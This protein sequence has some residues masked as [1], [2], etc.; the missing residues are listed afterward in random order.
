MLKTFSILPGLFA[1]LSLLTAVPTMAQQP[2]LSGQV[3]DSATGSPLS[4]VYI[5]AY[6]GNKSTA[7][8]YTDDNGT[9][10]FPEGRIITAVSASLLGYKAAM[11]NIVPGTQHIEIRMTP[12]KLE[13]R[14]ASVQASVV[15]EKGD[16]LSYTAQAFADGTER[17]L[18]ELLEK[19]PGIT[20]NVGTGT[21]Y[22]NGQAINK[23]YVEGM[24]LMGNRYG[25]VTQNLASDKIARVEVLQRH[26]PVQALQGLDPSAS[27]AINIILKEN[28]RGSW[29]LGAYAAAGAPPLPLFSSSA[30]LTRFAKRSQ[31]LFLL[32]GNNLGG[33]ILREL[34]EQQYLGR[35]ARWFVIDTEN[36]DADFASELRPARS[37]LPLPRR[38]WYDNLSGLGTLNHLFKINGQTQVKL[39][40]NGAAERYREMSRSEEEIRFGEGDILTIREDRSLMDTRYYADLSG[41]LEHNAGDHYFRD[42]VMVAAQWRDAFSALDHS[43]PYSQSFSLPSLKIQN[44]LQL[45]RRLHE[46][47]AFTLSSDSR[48]VRNNHMAEYATASYDAVQTLTVQDFRSENSAETIFRTGRLRWTGTAGLDLMWSGTD[49]RLT[50]LES[51]AVTENTV[52]F[53]VFCATPRLRVDCHPAGQAVP[54]CN[55]GPRADCS[56]AESYT[57]GITAVEPVLGVDRIHRFQPFSF[58]PGKPA[59]HPSDAELA[60]NRTPGQPAAHRHLPHRCTTSLF[61]P[62]GHV[63]RQSVRQPLQEAQ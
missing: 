3:T 17:A 40:L 14:A 15:E 2:P 10:S 30:M 26:Q 38:Y 56:V 48:F 20:V 44:L 9:F 51:L 57:V 35:N 54:D 28:E 16:T 19:L 21:I 45:T 31:D 49:T 61:Q 7:Y 27:S 12:A 47:Q 4:R 23:F 52:R 42:E 29:A 41:S 8:T 11:Q 37:E 59:G 43:S 5:A 63:F 24:D 33:D 60:D 25:V 53:N 18:G 39:S 32:K 13:I 6:D 34:Q 58:R 1:V 50:G 22:H 62:S 36:M 55:A 46:E